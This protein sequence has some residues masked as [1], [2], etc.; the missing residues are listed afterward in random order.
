MGK[1]GNYLQYYYFMVR[2]LGSHEAVDDIVNHYKQLEV[3]YK[4]FDYED[5]E[6]LYDR[7]YQELLT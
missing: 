3:K 2:E 6:D 1:S 4:Q 7:K 5:L